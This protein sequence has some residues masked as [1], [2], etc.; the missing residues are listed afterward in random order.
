MRWLIWTTVASTL[1]SALA[2]QRLAPVLNKVD[3]VQLIGLNAPTQLIAGER[4]PVYGG[5][6]ADSQYLELRLRVCGTNGCSTT[7]WGP[8]M[9]DGE[10]W[11]LL[12]TIMVPAAGDYSSE[13]LIYAET[14][15]GAWRIAGKH[16]WEVSVE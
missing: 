8:W 9:V 13:L 4:Y 7:S 11:D 16:V 5:V 10:D 6:I 15:F 2:L 12:G 14:Y 3:P 1:I